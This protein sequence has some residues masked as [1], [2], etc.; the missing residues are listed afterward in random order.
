MFLI[1]EHKTILKDKALDMWL[2]IQKQ[3]ACMQ[4]FSF[5]KRQEVESSHSLAFLI[6]ITEW[7]HMNVHKN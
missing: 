2:F 6:L 5:L 7:D 4:I 3:L 1:V